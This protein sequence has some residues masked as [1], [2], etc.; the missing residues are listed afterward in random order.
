MVYIIAEQEQVKGENNYPEYED[1]LRSVQDAAFARA[2]EVWAGWQPGGLTPANNKFG[3]NLL[4]KNDVANDV[5]TST[6]SSSY[7]FNK[8]ITATGWQDFFRYT[9][10]DDTL[11]AYAGFKF[12]NDVL[13]IWQIRIEIEDRLLPIIDIQSAQNMGKFSILFK[14]DEG[15]E[16][17]AGPR[18]R[19]LI[20]MY[21]GTTG[22]QRVV[23]IGL[24]LYRDLS[25]VIS[26][27]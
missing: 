16:I 3:V 14:W 7:D 9:V 5:S 8:T 12:T 25:R 18:N 6:L 22:V 17:I 10:P 19:V 23:P 24:H 15:G 1:V 4:R 11:H 21:A 27:T 26:E 13:R 20:R 2:A